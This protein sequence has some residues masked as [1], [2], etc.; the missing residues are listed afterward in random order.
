[1]TIWAMVPARGG[2]K[3][4]PGKNLIPLAGVPLLDYGIRAGKCSDRIDRIVCS[5]DDDAIAARARAL[6]VDIAERPAELAGDE[7]PVAEV[8]R[9]LLASERARGVS[10]PDWLVL[11]QPTSPFLIVS[12]IAALLDALAAR[13]AAR[14][15][16]TIVPVSHNHH[17][18]NQRTVGDGLVTFRFANER[19]AAYNKQ[20]KPVLYV[21][22]NL[23][24]VRPSALESGD[25]FFA[26][27]SVGVEIERPYDFDLDGPDDVPVAEALIAHGVVRLPHMADA[28]SAMPGRSDHAR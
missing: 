21:F 11:I 5:T 24:A 2:S 25:D 7:T 10:I 13:S 19:R 1:M 9:E 20:R 28:M 12:H 14:S 16:Q 22:G 18:W 17:A 8:A 27:P 4:I 26:E 3:S 23:I 15:G 6:G